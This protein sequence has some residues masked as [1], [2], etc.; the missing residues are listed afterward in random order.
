ME[1]WEYVPLFDYFYEEFKGKAFKVTV[2]TYV[3]SDSG[4]GVVHS[5]PGF[6]EDDYN[7]CC[8]YKVI[9]PDNPPVPLDLEGNFT[10]RISDFKGMYIKDADKEIK[11]NLKTRGRLLRDG[12]IKHAYPFCWRSD[13]PLI[14]KAV[15]CWFIK[16]KKKFSNQ[17]LIKSIKNSIHK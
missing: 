7:V 8:R 17:E 14:Y 1:G 15:H 11:K 6:G 4:T 10:E 2:D 3:T 16:V 5:S 12:Q 9:S 13:T